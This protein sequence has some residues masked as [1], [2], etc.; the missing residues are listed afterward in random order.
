MLETPVGRLRLVG[1]VEAISYLVLVFVTMPLKY[2]AGMPTPNKVSGMAHG[3]L[4]VAF[5]IALALAA[6]DRR[7]GVGRVAAVFVASLIPFGYF[8]VDRRVRDA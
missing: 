4:F 2:L 5:V 6:R 8:A 7:W 1:L 3:V